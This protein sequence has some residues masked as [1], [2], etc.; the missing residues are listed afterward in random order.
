MPR[1]SDRYDVWGQDTWTPVEEEHFA[2][3][4]GQPSR[5]PPPHHDDRPWYES[6]EKGWRLRSAV[7][8]QTPVS[9]GKCGRSTRRLE[10]VLV[11]VDG[12]LWHL[13]CAESR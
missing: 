1:S 3:E 10:D 5:E 8:C 11:L 7:L 12:E 6:A 13:E 2:A 4:M 9:C